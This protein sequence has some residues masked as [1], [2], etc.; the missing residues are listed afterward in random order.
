M[1]TGPAAGGAAVLAPNA[2]GGAAS[3]P[4]H[5]APVHGAAAQLT[6]VPALAQLCTL[7]LARHVA[8]LH[9]V[10][11]GLHSFTFQVNLSCLCAP[12]NPT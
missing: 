2:T 6:A 8:H 7:S 1:S 9:D 10:G 12:R 3:A 5:G 11:R 4:A